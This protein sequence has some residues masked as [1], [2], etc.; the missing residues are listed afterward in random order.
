MATEQQAR[1]VRCLPSDPGGERCLVRRFLVS[2]GCIK[3]LCDLLDATDA[4]IQTVALEGLENILKV[5]EAEKQLGTVGLA[6]G[7]MYAEFIDEAG[8][9]DKIEFL[10]THKN[11][12]IYEKSIK[13]LETYFGLEEDFEQQQL[14][15][16][17]EEGQTAYSFGQPPATGAPT[18][19]FNFS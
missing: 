2:Q 9:L 11:N 15:P 10:Q 4:R 8:G 7:N 12:D 5:G 3:P 17:I 19:G 14:A 1:G 13:I 16:A 6:G 18:G